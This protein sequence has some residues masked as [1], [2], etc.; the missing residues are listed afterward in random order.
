MSGVR[1]IHVCWNHNGIIR[2]ISEVFEEADI[3]LL[4]LFDGIST[5]LGNKAAGSLGSPRVSGGKFS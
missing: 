5:Y 1:K 4:E 2:E 3:H